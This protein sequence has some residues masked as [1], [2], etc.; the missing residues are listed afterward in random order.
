MKKLIQVLTENDLMG[1]FGFCL[2][3]AVIV[4]AGLTELC[5]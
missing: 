2:V 4:G 1:W 5:K 3:A